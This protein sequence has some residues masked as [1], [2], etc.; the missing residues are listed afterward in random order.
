MPSF[1]KY[2]TGVGWSFGLEIDGIEID[3][4]QSI[5]GL[6]VGVDTIELKQNTA[7]GKYVNKWLPGRK[8]SGQITVSRGVTDDTK[9]VDWINSVWDGKINPA[10]KNGVVKI[11]NYEGITVREFNLVNAW[12]SSVEYGTMTAGDQSVLTET[13][14]I[15]C[16]SIEPAK[17]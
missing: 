11:F 12:P 9:L 8:H 5:N 4:I 3:Q 16:D 13:C 2:D 14:T 10:R 6:T 7:D 15:V 1:D 17:S